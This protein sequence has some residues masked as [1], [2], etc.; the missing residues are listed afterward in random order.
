MT[1]DDG[2]VCTTDSCDPASGCVFTNN[3]EACDDGQ[4]CTEGE[5][6]AAGACTGGAPT[7]CDDGVACTTDSCDPAT[8]CVHTTDDTQ[9]DDGEVCTADVCDETLGCTS[10]PAP[11]PC[12]SSETCAEQGFCHDGTC[13]A[14]RYDLQC[15]GL[16]GS[17]ICAVS[18]PAGSEVQC[19]LHLARA[20]FAGAKPAALQFG[21]TYPATTLKLE[22]MEDFTCFSEDLCVAFPVPPTNLV[23]QGHAVSIAPS[24]YA[25][26]DGAG[27]VLI[28]NFLSTTAPLSEAFVNDSDAVEGD[29]EL[30]YFRMTL[31]DTVST[32]SPAVMELNNVVPVDADGFNLNSFF[33]WGK[34]ISFQ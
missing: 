29:S 9:C 30:A 25:D 10:A 22:A 11:G 15:L 24:S 23:P 31:V 12:D 26:W 2:E 32:G 20:T 28:A 7:N 3:T 17:E 16:S 27:T 1:C 5:A 33:F 18:G 8:G 21:V 13:S 19:P 6:C 34:I 14:V 4:P